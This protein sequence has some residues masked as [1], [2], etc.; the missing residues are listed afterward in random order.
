MRLAGLLRPLIQREWSSLLARFNQLPS[1]TLEDFLF[2]VDRTSLTVVR[3][4]LYELQ[5]AQCFYC[6]GRLRLDA[7]EVDHFIPWAR[8]P[9]NAIENLVAAHA[10][11]NSSKSDYLAAEPHL[12][13]WLQRL[14][15]QGNAL[16]QISSDVAWE[17]A[18]QTSF[19]VARG[20]YLRL[21]EATLLWERSQS[22]RAAH[23]DE[24]R[25]LLAA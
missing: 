6:S 2:G 8:H 3:S 20:I 1:S 13:R 15:D 25:T 23:R 5:S 22:F 7:I 10:R 24:L 11:C 4:P 14:Q 19:A 12:A 16:Q 18:G 9:N 17:S 21:P